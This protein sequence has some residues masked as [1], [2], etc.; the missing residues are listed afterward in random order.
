[1]QGQG[2][3]TI[4]ALVVIAIACAGL[5]FFLVGAETGTVLEALGGLAAYLGTWVYGLMRASYTASP[6]PH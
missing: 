6:S 5:F 3:A 2:L 4:E 1:M